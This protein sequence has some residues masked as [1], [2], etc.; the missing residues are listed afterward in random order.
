MGG[1]I[2]AGKRGEERRREEDRRG[3]ECYY[4][5]INIESIQLNLSYLEN[6]DIYRIISREIYVLGI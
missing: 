6:A 5:C 4:S 2:S 1:F 3:E